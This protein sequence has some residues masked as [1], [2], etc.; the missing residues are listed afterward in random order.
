MSS[1]FLEKKTVD[2]AEDEITYD[3]ERKVSRRAKNFSRQ[4]R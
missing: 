1:H 3:D 4:F 2:F